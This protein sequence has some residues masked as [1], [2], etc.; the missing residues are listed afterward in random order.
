LPKITLSDREQELIAL[1]AAGHTDAS[2]A[3]RLGISARSVSTLVRGL[4]DR[5]GVQNRFQLGIALGYLRKA[6][7]ERVEREP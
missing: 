7:V 4:M 2:A 1:L 6:S 5:L 3:H